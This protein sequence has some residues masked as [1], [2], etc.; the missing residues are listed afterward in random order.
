[1]RERCG[2]TV[3]SCGETI[4][5][6]S[7]SSRLFFQFTSLARLS[8]RLY[9]YDVFEGERFTH[10][11]FIYDAFVALSSGVCGTRAQRTHGTRARRVGQT[12]EICAQQIIVVVLHFDLSVSGILLAGS[13]FCLLEDDTALRPFRSSAARPFVPLYPSSSSLGLGGEAL[14]PRCVC[15]T[16]PQKMRPHFQL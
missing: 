7:L 16:F 12:M 4:V 2:I 14:L 5:S 8:G 15:V 9:R 3:L 11:R 6:T 13:A 10:G 1:M